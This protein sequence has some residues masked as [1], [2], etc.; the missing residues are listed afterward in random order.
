MGEGQKLLITVPLEAG[1]TATVDGREAELE[2]VDGLIAV[3]MEAGTHEVA[4]EYHTPGL[5]P[6]ALVSAAGCALAGAW[7][8][9]TVRRRSA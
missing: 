5:V 6:G 1:W 4:L 2:D 9:V 7:A 3:P 8:T